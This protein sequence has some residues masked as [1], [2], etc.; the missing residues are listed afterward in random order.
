MPEVHDASSARA[1]RS[2]A[3]LTVL[4]VAIGAGIATAATLPF[5]QNDNN[6]FRRYAGWMLADPDPS[7]PVGKAAFA[8]REQG[9][10]RLWQLRPAGS[11]WSEPG[12]D[13]GSVLL[14]WAPGIWAARALGS[15]PLL[16]LRWIAAAPRAVTAFAIVGFG[17]LVVRS[18]LRRRRPAVL[19]VAPALALLFGS[20]YVSSYYQSF[21]RESASLLFAILTLLAIAA[22]DH[23][24]TAEWFVG[25]TAAGALLL[26]SAPARGLLALPLLLVL[27]WGLRRTAIA[28]RS[29]RLAVALA[30]I[31]LLATA[32]A[33]V[34]SFPTW[35]ASKRSFNA[36]FFGLLPLSSDPAAHLER[37]GLPP[38]AGAFVGHPVWDPAPREFEAKLDLPLGTAQ[39]ANVLVHEPG[40]VW[41]AAVAVADW[42]H[43]TAPGQRRYFER[44]R[45]PPSWI[46]W[47]NPWGAMQ[48]AVF[49]RG[50]PLLFLLA[51]ATVCGARLARRD[52]GERRGVSLALFFTSA[53]A[54]LEMGVKILGDG[55]MDRM[56]HL[57]VAN[58]FVGAAACFAIWRAL[59]AG[60]STTGIAPPAAAPTAR[61]SAAEEGFEVRR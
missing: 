52:D 59:L 45:P 21:Y 16:D 41:K 47:R 20:A 23:L 39:I 11:A 10:K 56:R 27:G 5:G 7:E 28:P 15:E 31:V 30:T 22:R 54:L 42:M 6:D 44:E 35:L 58:L 48:H 37:L 29:I 57:A 14:V 4:V 3:R 19:L 13:A 51:G 34:A 33:A 18:S 17:V 36:L 1:G 55:A 46:P 53:G 2:L 24:R 61:E 25:V 50:V 26:S 32:A 40:L 9:W 60:G 8:A 38:E 49:P 43:L 12:R